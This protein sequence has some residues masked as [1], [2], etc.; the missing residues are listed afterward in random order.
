MSRCDM[1]DADLP[2]GGAP[3]GRDGRPVL[4]VVG[5]GFCD[6]SYV[7][8][9]GGGF[10]RPPLPVIGQRWAACSV[11]AE[12]PLRSARVEHAHDGATT[13]CGMDAGSVAAYRHYWKPRPV[14]VWPWPKSCGACRRVARERV[15]RWSAE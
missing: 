6:A 9:E 11:P 3:L 4:L 2:V 1:C 7:C 13:L 12:H 8:L 14:R 15:R 5:C 10:R